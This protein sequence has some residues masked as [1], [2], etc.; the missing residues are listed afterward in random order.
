MLP[1]SARAVI[2]QPHPSGKGAMRM[3]ENEG[4]IWDGYVDIFDGGPTVTAKTDQIRAV[5]DARE[6]TVVGKGEGGKR[7]LL[8][9]SS[10]RLENF[11]ACTA[12]V[13]IVGDSEV[14]LDD[15][16]RRLLE[17]DPGDGILAVGR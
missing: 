15:S 10:G 17:V 9:L 14:A 5:R 2:G 12:E 4:F 7:E 8:L 6:L 11:L 1:E 3:L 16:C 13:E